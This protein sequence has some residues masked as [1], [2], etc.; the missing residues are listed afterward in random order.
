MSCVTMPIAARRLSCVTLRDVL[1]VDHDA[2]ALGVVEAQQQ[3]HQRRLADAR[4]AHQAD[5]LAR[6]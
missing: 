2:S 4:A 5:A 3:V 6:A 1:A